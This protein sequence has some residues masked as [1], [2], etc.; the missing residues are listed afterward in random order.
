MNPHFVLSDSSG[1][2][3][4]YVVYCRCQHLRQCCD[5]EKWRIGANDGEQW[6]SPTAMLATTLS[7]VATRSSL[8]RATGIEPAFSA[9]ERE[10][11][12][13]PND[14]EGPHALISE[15]LAK[16]SLGLLP[17]VST[18]T[19]PP[20]EKANTHGRQSTI[21]IGCWFFFGDGQHVDWCCKPDE[22]PRFQRTRDWSKRSPIL[23]TISRGQSTRRSSR[24]RNR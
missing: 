15:E 6:R 14:T 3:L 13:R 21:P 10:F 9:W 18:Q 20:F 19:Y 1:K 2:V 8:E 17:S 23:S 22:R 16:L 4:A 11:E 5:S 12:C 24:L 7:V